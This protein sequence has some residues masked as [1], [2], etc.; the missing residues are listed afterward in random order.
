[1][2]AQHV[3]ECQSSCVLRTFI[4]HLCLLYVVPLQLIVIYIRSEQSKVLCYKVDE[5][6]VKHKA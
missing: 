3:M 2:V 4:V 5:T 1:M 6:S